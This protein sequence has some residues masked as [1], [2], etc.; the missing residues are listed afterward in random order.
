MG[1]AILETV[2]LSA[3]GLW[4]GALG[5]TAAMAAIIFPQM[6]DLDPV[7]GGPLGSYPGDQGVLAAGVVMARVF[8]VFDTVQVA[9]A[10]AALITAVALSR[11]RAARWRAGRLI[12]T[13]LACAA[14]AWYLL[15]VAAPLLADLSG[16][17]DAAAAGDTVTADAF[18]AAFDA[19]HHVAS[20]WLGIVG[21][22][23]LTA[24]V[25]G[26][27]GAGAREPR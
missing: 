15:T 21:V 1:R 14:L 2:Y 8:S 20:R 10:S 6:R 9:C 26:G 19:R 4:A 13:L 25:T 18:R 11:A 22:L 5:M 17:W 23:A 3:L 24:L 16:F 27:L 7:L 12:V